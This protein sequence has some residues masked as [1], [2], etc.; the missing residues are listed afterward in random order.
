MRPSD[1]G[2]DLPSGGSVAGIGEIP[3][4]TTTSSSSYTN[5]INVRSSGAGYVTLTDP[6]TGVGT[7]SPGNGGTMPSDATV[8]A[9]SVPVYIREASAGTSSYY[10]AIKSASGGTKKTTAASDAGDA[11]VRV[12]PNSTTAFGRLLISETDPT[13][14]GRWK[15]TGTNSLT[16]AQIGVEVTS[17]AEVYI[18]AML[19]MVAF[20]PYEA[21]TSHGMLI[22]FW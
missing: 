18:P 10:T 21:P 13:T 15:V 8:K 9:V 14:G 5:Q 11:T 6:V 3:V 7:Y 22:M 19:A 4:T 12:S 20:S 2:D 16:N 1:W 17:S